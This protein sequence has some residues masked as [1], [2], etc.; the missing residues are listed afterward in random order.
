MDQKTPDSAQLDPEAT[1][2]TPHVCPLRNHRRRLPADLDLLR[3]ERPAAHYFCDDCSS[4][5][6]RAIEG[7]LDSA[8]W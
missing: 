4:A 5:N 7:R 6:L 3:G 8:W 2:T 1:G